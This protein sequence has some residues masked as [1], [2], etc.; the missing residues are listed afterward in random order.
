[1]AFISCA[2][3]TVRPGTEVPVQIHTAIS[4]YQSDTK[5]HISG[6]SFPNGGTYGI[7]VCLEGSTTVA[8]KSNSWNIKAQYSNSPAGWTYYYVGNLNNG[9]P[10]ASGNDN[11]TLTARPNGELA[12]LYAYAPYL[13]GAFSYNPTR[14]PFSFKD[15]NGSFQYYERNYE[16][17]YAVENLTGSNRNLDPSSDYPLSATFTFRHAFALLVFNFRLLYDGSVHGITTA[18]LS[19]NPDYSGPSRAKLYSRG[20]FNALTG[21]VN[22]DDATSVQTFRSQMLGGINLN[23]TVGQQFY[24]MIAPTEFYDDEL[25]L[26]FNMDLQYA[27]PY[28]LQ[29]ADVQHGDGTSAFKAGYVYNFN[30]TIDNYVHLDGI[31]VSDTWPEA[32]LGSSEI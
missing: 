13:Q 20:T 10:S 23:T 28:I 18:E 17:M 2:K 26:K 4:T 27:W 3:E 11:I 16:V 8:H 25:M 32:S 6:D 9:T 29:N 30:F 5:A 24:M 31:T 14:I 12:D 19:F 15:D 22:D 7:F 1:M 21:T